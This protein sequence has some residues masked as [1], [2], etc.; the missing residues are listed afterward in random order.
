MEKQAEFTVRFYK[1]YPGESEADSKLVQEAGPFFD[2]IDARIYACEHFL[3][4]PSEISFW[5]IEPS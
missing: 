2:A 3:D 4:H 5:R 1:Q